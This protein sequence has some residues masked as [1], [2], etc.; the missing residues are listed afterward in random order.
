MPARLAG[1]L[2]VCLSAYTYIY[3]YTYPCTHYLV[4][5][6][7]YIHMHMYTHTYICRYTHTLQVP[8]IV[9]IGNMYLQAPFSV[10]IRDTRITRTLQST[11]RFVR[12]ADSYAALEFSCRRCRSRSN[13]FRLRRGYEAGSQTKLPAARVNE[14]RGDTG[15]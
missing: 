5:V 9:S 1:W 12:H 13:L 2:S 14:F 6:S 15:L 10:K 4:N 11:H 3:I 8:S 7:T